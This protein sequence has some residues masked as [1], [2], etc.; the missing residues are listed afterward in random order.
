[1]LALTLGAG[2]SLC[3]QGTGRVDTVHV[4]PLDSA[5]Y[6]ARNQ[7]AIFRRSLPG[8][9]WR[10]APVA[11]WEILPGFSNV[12]AR[13][14][15]FDSA[16]AQSQAQAIGEASYQHLL[17]Q[18]GVRT[19]AIDTIPEARRGLFGLSP[20]TADVS[21]DGQLQF[22]VSTT[23]TRNLACTPLQ[24]QDIASGCSGGFKGPTIDNTVLLSSRGIFAQRIHLDIDFDSK[25]DYAAGQTISVSYQGL[26]DEKIR[27]ID[28]GTVQW[29]P[30]PSRFF[31]A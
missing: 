23:R 31:T 7:A 18:F 28:I 14:A 27:R 11:P 3:A 29:T 16:L 25:R 26:E 12:A 22:Q 10:Y 4:L 20:Q 19:L 2:R 5:G 1:M 9:A 17:R 24:V 21:F 30:P 15:A 8:A 6:I 13:V